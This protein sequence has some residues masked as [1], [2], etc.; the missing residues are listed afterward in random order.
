VIEMAMA[1]QM[2]REAL[3]VAAKLALP[4]LVVASLVGFAVSLLQSATQLQDSAL[5]F[6]PKLAGVA[7]AALVLLP[8]MTAVLVDYASRVLA[9]LGAGF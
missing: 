1:V 9:G 7:V 8:W 4:L 6:V 5:S 2:G 3:L